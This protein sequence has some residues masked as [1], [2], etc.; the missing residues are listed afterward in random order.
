MLLT[1]KILIAIVALLHL[2]FLI[3]EM[4]LWTKPFGRR[5]FGLKKEFAEESKTLAANQGL[6][7][8]ILAAGL[9]WGLFTEPLNN[10]LT[11]FAL[12]AV[13]VAGLYGGF[14]VN[15][16]ILWIQAMPAV[17]ALAFLRLALG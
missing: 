11:V 3:I 17:L 10:Q 6:Y 14:T 5:T 13:V 1:A 12:A 16:R 9:L 8:G 15:R 2:F 4:F 7:N